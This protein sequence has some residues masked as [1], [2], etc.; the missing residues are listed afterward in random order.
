[1]NFR[2]EYKNQPSTAWLP[3]T[4][5]NNE[6]QAIQ[7]ANQFANQYSYVRVV[8]AGGKMVYQA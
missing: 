7:Q 1:M 6:G 2:V 3:L 8:D 4:M 5:S